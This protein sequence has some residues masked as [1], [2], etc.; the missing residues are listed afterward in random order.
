MTMEHLR[1]WKSGDYGWNIGA[2]TFGIGDIFKAGAEGCMYAGKFAQSL[3]GYAFLVQ[4][5]MHGA[6]QGIMA[7]KDL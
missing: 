1:F 2:T 4:G 6:S 7:M 3:K 5:G